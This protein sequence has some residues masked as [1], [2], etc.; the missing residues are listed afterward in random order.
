MAITDETLADARR[1]KPKALQTLLTEG[2]A[3]ARRIAHA[4]SG[5]DRVAGAVAELL[6]RRS[7]RMLPRWRDPSSPENWFYHHAVLTTRGVGAP[8]P[9]P[10]A[11]PLVVHGAT[12]VDDPAYVA[13]VRALRHLPAQQREAFI[14]H[15][16]ERLNPR[17]LGV[18]MDCSASAADVHLRAATDALRAVGGERADELAAKL[19]SAYANLRAAQPEP[20]PA[21]NI[22]VRHVRRRVWAKRVVRTIV[23]AAVLSGLGWAGWYFRDDLM[24]LAQERGPGSTTAPATQP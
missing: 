14:L 3:P 15:H 1:L 23:W 11:D 10:H 12:A 21:I 22:Y 8:A 20:F 7:I 18:A 19:T 24:R 4:L 17:L 2:Y 9:D 6:V 5:D 16:G 13:F